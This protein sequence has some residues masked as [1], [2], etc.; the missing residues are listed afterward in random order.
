MFK[1]LTHSSIFVFIIAELSHGFTVQKIS[2]VILFYLNDNKITLIGYL[3]IWKISVNNSRCQFNLHGFL[4]WIIGSIKS[5]N[6]VL[7]EQEAYLW[8]VF[9]QHLLFPHSYFISNVQTWIWY[10]LYLILQLLFIFLLLALY[11]SLEIQLQSITLWQGPRGKLLL[12]SVQVDSA[13]QLFT[14]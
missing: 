2:F 3:D 8:V 9:I 1:L 5:L 14:G 12:L 13:Q 4:R 10:S 6:F 11:L 7:M